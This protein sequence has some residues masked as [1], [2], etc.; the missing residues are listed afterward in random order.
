MI[1][2]NPVFHYDWSSIPREQ[3]SEKLTRQVIHTENATIARLTV[4]AG[5]SVPVHQHENEQVSMVVAGKLRFLLGDREVIV[6]SGQ[7]IVLQPDEPHGV[8]ILEDTDV[9][10][11]FVPRRE[12]WIR[13]E[14]AY[15]RK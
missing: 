8:E 12:D 4:R 13:G 10:D 9:I 11:L 7:W 2:C 6:E 1:H 5:G 3:L 15:L 14:D